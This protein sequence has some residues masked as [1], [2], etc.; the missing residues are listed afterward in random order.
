MVYRKARNPTTNGQE[1][2][3]GVLVAEKQH[4]IAQMVDLRNPNIQFSLIE[5][6]AFKFSP[7]YKKIVVFVGNITQSFPLDELENYFECLQ[8]MHEIF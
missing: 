2:D 1:K 5:I 7:N 6:I 8:K 4:Q 3:E